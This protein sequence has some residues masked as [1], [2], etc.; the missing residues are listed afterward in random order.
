M[1]EV[2][3]LEAKVAAGLLFGLLWRHFVEL[4][5]EEVD[6]ALRFVLVDVLDRFIVR[7][8]RTANERYLRREGKRNERVKEMKR[9]KRAMRV[10]DKMWESERRRTLIA[11]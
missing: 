5:I 9:K 7:K 10:K 11:L 3:D 8:D 4:A 1:K 2:R 6:E